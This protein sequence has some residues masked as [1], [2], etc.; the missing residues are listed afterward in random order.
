MTFPIYRLICRQAI[1]LAIGAPIIGAA[2]VAGLSVW[3]GT[4]IA[5]APA[6]TC[7]TFG[8]LIGALLGAAWDEHQEGRAR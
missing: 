4:P 3:I 8:A 1:G 2:I 7:Y 6:A 5:G